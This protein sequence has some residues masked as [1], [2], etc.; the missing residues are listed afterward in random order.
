LGHLQVGTREH[1][2]LEIFVKACDAG[3]FLFKSS[4]LVTMHVD[5]LRM[6]INA[7]RY[8]G[9]PLPFGLKVNLAARA[10]EIFMM[11]MDLPC[12]MRNLWPFVQTKEDLATMGLLDAPTSVFDPCNATYGALAPRR[13]DKAEWLIF[14]ATWLGPPHYIAIGK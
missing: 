1:D 3:V 8:S 12:L 10:G 5:Q 4:S 2:E 9:V 14:K 7:V 6:H 11:A 13:G